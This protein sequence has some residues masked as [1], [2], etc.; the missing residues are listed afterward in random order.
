V[1][2]QEWSKIHSEGVDE[3]TQTSPKVK[4]PPP[5]PPS[6]AHSS[7]LSDANRIIYPDGVMG[8][9]VN[10]MMNYIMKGGNRPPDFK[11]F[12]DLVEIHKKKVKKVK[13]L[14]IR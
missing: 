5:P 3:H 6:P 4:S 2:E 8:S 1:S 13:W 10:D 9:N 12:I 14:P 11:R 7:N